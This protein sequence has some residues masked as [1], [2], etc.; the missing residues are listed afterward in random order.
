MK[1]VYLLPLS[2]P[3]TRH[4]GEIVYLKKR[5][6]LCGFCLLPQTFGK[7]EVQ[8]RARC[9]FTLKQSI[10][11]VIA[12]DRQKSRQ[13]ARPISF[14]FSKNCLSVCSLNLC[15]GV[16]NIPGAMVHLVLN[17]QSKLLPSPPPLPRPWAVS[18]AHMDTGHTATSQNLRPLEMSRYRAQCFFH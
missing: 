17:Y 16:G 6:G 5:V 7:V 2:I 4:V 10:E 12:S 8:Y 9:F 13:R 15:L 14:N 18:R 3:A 1:I 11:I